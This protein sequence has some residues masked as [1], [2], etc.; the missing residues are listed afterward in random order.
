MLQIS[1]NKKGIRIKEIYFTNGIFDGNSD[2]SDII[3]YVQAK[4]YFNGSYEFMNLHINLKESEKDLF[5]A[6]KKGTRYEIKRAQEKDVNS[7]ITI[8]KPTK[9]EIL[10][11][12]KCYDSFAVSKKISVANEKKLFALNCIGSL[13]M[14][15][16]SNQNGCKTWHVYLCDHEEMRVRLLYSLRI[17]KEHDSAAMMAFAGRQNRFLHW[18]DMLLFK[19]LGYKIYDFG[20]AGMDTEEVAKVT[21]FKKEF[22]GEDRIEY[23][24]MKGNTIKGKT[25]VLLFKLYERL[26]GL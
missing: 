23:S 18:K 14:T 20:G 22:G 8:N 12:K 25:A 13:T 16:A 26:R 4:D 19:E 5:A 24:G 3:F 6:I 21:K 11:F 15:I 7:L 1:R 9:E 10:E 17:L 2:H